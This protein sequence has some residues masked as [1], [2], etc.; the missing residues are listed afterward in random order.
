MRPSRLNDLPSPPPGKTG[1]PWDEEA[2]ELPDR[3]PDGSQWPKISIVT[4][5]YNQGQYLEETIRSVL[6][7]GYPNL[8][9]IIIDGGSTDNSVEII[10]KYDQFLRFWKSASDRGQADAINQGFTRASGTVVAFIN[11]D[12]YYLPRA[13]ASVAKQMVLQDAGWCVSAVKGQHEPPARMELMP[14]RI[15]HSVR[16]V[17]TRDYVVPQ[18][19]MFFSS[20]ILDVV[21]TFDRDLHYCFDHGWI[22]RAVAGGH[23]PGMVDAITAVYR[24]QP[25]SKTMRQ[26]IEFLRENIEIATDVLG[27]L[28]STDTQEVQKVVGM[29]R[30]NY[31]MQSAW[32][33]AI[34]QGTLH[35]IWALL[36]AVGRRPGLFLY[37]ST[38]T[39]FLRLV[40]KLVFGARTGNRPKD[41]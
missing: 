14:L 3:M 9:Y 35:G 19:G 29:W 8:E 22:C 25:A 16:Q 5:S 40:G 18:P 12:D 17:V 31:A 26:G 11:S 13:L 10:Q 37:R 2:V 33:K 4:P 1:W 38:V 6:L 41:A 23:V 24:L 27:E 21:G 34:S 32:D 28:N 39:S 30:A 20:T 15:P 36:T 7:Q